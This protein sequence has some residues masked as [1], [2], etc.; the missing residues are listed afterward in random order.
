MLEYI[1]I[2]QA[3][4]GSFMANLPRR[5]GRL[6]IFEFF[7]PGPSNFG[8]AFGPTS[9]FLSASLMNLNR[10]TA[11]AKLGGGR[12][13]AASRGT[14]KCDRCWGRASFGALVSLQ[15]SWGL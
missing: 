13:S 10:R 7:Q 5:G 12:C 11:G 6:N 15:A 8:F 2:N 9:G 14:F 4:V 3:P 1:M